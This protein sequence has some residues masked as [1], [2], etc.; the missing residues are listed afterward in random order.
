[1]KEPRRLEPGQDYI[2]FDGDC[3]ICSYSAEVAQQIDQRRQFVIEPYQA[4][5]EA[6]LQRYGIS[7][8]ACDRKVQVITRRGRV[9]AGAF[10][11][12]YLLWQR[13]PWRLLILLIYA[14]PVLLVCEVIGYALVARNRQRLS[15]WFGLKACLL[16]R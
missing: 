14:V 8:N 9:Y 11:V 4:I 16:K 2:L 1:M 13:W 3:G 12:N 5:A 15:R 10:A 7:N 6:E